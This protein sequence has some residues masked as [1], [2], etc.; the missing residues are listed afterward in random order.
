MVLGEGAVLFALETAEHAQKR[1]AAIYCEVAGYGSTNDAYALFDTNADAEA[2][3]KAMQSA[4]AFARIEPDDLGCI[5][6]EGNGMVKTDRRETDAL[7]KVFGH[8]AKE[9][10]VTSN[11]G[12]VGHCLGAAGAFNVACSIMAVNDGVIPPTLHHQTPD[13]ECELNIVKKSMTEKVDTVMVN[14]FSLNGENSSVIIKKWE[15]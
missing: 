4:L 12:A 14:A 10:P 2:S 1:G 6:A 9:I 7:K 13:P 3:A 8:R 5:I 15:P 11:K